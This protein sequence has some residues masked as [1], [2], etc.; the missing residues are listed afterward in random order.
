MRGRA[1]DPDDAARY[2][3]AGW[4]G[5]LILSDVV[6]LH[7]RTRGDDAAFVTPTERATWAD[8][9][10]DADRIG[11]AIRAAGVQRG[12][13]VAVLV[14]DGPFVHAAFLGAERAGAVIV[15]IGAR[16][17][18]REVAHLISR[19]GAVLAVTDRTDVPVERRL[20]VADAL[21]GEPLGD[22][23]SLGPDEPFLLNSTSGTTGLPK[24]VVHTQNRW[25]Y[26]HQLAVAAGEFGD[27]E[28][29]LSAIPAP[30]GFGL[31]TAHFTPTILG[32]PTVMAE[33]FDA[34]VTLD[35]IARERVTVLACVSTQ[36]IL[37]LEE[38]AARPRD[39]SSLRVMFTGGEAVPYERAA[40]FEDRA[41]AMVLQFYGSNETGVLS[42]TTTRDSRERRLRTAGRVIGDMHV[43]LFSEDG[44]SVA[45]P[46]RG[47]P[48][49]K[50]PATCVGY[51]DDDAANEALFTPDGWMLMGDVVEIDDEGYLKVVGRVSDFIIRGGKN[52]SAPAVEDEVGT[53]PGVAMVAVV[54][55]PD[56]VFGERVCAVVEPRA[57]YEAMTLADITAHLDSRGV[58]KEWWP[59]R[60]VVM[61]SL[62][63]SSGGKVAKGELRKMVAEG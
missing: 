54:G 35:L 61:E 49:C 22:Y 33:R 24:C 59:E 46:G 57:G 30:F 39:L 20:T 25:F 1:I 44:G 14:P 16:A 5:N 52:I 42:G 32:A 45:I 6:S 12:E 63:R 36:F 48:G 19:T 50:G 23:Q 18:E 15:G 21:G 43:R 13:R 11:G 4:W 8:Y 28:V 47:I 3:A 53:H 26:F 10:R 9:H 56:P 17:G 41:G 29:F 60:L 2:H 7:A 38:Q 37:M 55:V 34:G 31:W 40:E 62:P 27:G 58:T 51:W